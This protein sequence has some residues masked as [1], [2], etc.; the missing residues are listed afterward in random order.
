MTTIY[1]DESGH[2]GDM[3]DSGTG[4]DFKRQPYFALAGVGLQDE[5]EWDA[6]LQALR[7]RHRV[8]SG[9]PGARSL[10]SRPEFSAAVIH[11]LLDR[12]APLFVELVDKRYFICSCITS[13]QLLPSCL[14]YPESMRLDFL[15]NAVADFLH[16]HADAHVLDSF[17]ASCLTPEAGTLHASLASLRDLATHTA[18]EEEEAAAQVAKGFGRIVE[19]ANTEYHALSEAQHQPW[20]EFLP[21]P[22]LNTSSTQAWTLPNLTSFMRIYAR[23]LLYYRHCLADVRLVHDQNFEVQRILGQGKAAAEGPDRAMELLC[24]PPSDHRFEEVAA[25][26]FRQSHEAAGVQMAEVVA[27][28][29]MRF[30]RDLHAGRCVCP[31][32]REA[33][34]RLISEGDDRTGYG[35]KQVVPTRQVRIGAEEA[36]A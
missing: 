13:F 25:L 29:T 34:M 21:P 10:A 19:A 9:E 35:L 2:S 8:P 36:W 28:A 22:E 27:G 1:V 4:Y 3:V 31:A 32:L 30:F 6:H 20:L 18:E 26:D 17:V 15:R 16:V 12:R 24:T 7:D 23:I 33:M 5:E 11:A 14:G